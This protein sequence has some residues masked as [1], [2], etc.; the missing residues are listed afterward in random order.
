[1][2]LD[3]QTSCIKVYTELH[4]LPYALQLLAGHYH[5]LLPADL[6]FYDFR[7]PEARQAQADLARQYRLHGFCYHHYWFHGRRILERP[8]D[9]VLASGQPD[10]PFCLSWANE[11]WTRTWD[12]LD[13]QVLLA[14]TYSEED[15][16][17]HIRWLC[18][19]FRDE[20]YIHV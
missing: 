7:M 8:F 3:I 15:D 11:N 14:Q 16:R 1:H 19:S 9:E 2:I 10:F 20:R 18:A 4:R 13:H 6:G 12:G 17:A 5:T